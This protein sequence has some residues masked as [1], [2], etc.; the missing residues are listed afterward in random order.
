M[1]LSYQEMLKRLNGVI[2]LLP[3]YFNDDETLDL[4]AMRE[5]AEFACEQ[6]EGHDG[7]IMIAGS[8]SEFYA[9]TDEENLQ[10]IDTVVKT[11]NGRVPVIAGTGR[12]AT[13]LTIDVSKRAQDLGID[14]ALVSNPYYMQITEDG[15]YRHFSKIAEALDIGV[16]IYN[17][18]STSKMFVPP[19]I[20]AKLSKIPNIIASK[21]NATTIEKY[22]W[23]KTETD[24]DEFKVC[25]GI[26]HLNYMF[27]APFGCPAMVTELLLLAPTLVLDFY[28]ACKAQDFAEATRLMDQIIP[29]HKFISR[30]VAKRS[31]PSTNDPEIGGRAT[32]LYQ[33]VIKRAMEFLGL[34]GGVVREPLENL[35]D[36]EIAELKEVLIQC[37]LL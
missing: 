13:G 33:S 28:D 24:P 3:T 10:M 14:C 18:P 1:S 15:L 30:C 21:E 4:G 2:G 20:I 34:P 5:T 19:N 8:T 36:S 16:M 26:G 37:K 31:V 29:Y 32:A 25:C 23:M 17:N 6:L 35:T 9:M 11:V 27:E 22:Y 12:A 7:A